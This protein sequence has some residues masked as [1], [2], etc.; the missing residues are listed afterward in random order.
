[1]HR[2]KKK[3]INW[4]EVFHDTE[5]ALGI[6]WGRGP[7]AWR[8]LQ[9]GEDL[10][11][12]HSLKWKRRQL[13]AN[14]DHGGRTVETKSDFPTRWRVNEWQGWFQTYFRMWLRQLKSDNLDFLW[15]ADNELV[16]H[17]STRSFVV[18]LQAWC[19]HRTIIPFRMKEREKPL[20]ILS[21]R[22]EWLRAVTVKLEGH[23]RVSKGR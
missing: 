11:S 1:M 12:H 21:P 9:V 18:R 16:S 4:F 17:C 19:L 3:I 22:G 7:R 10:C 23:Q 15:V 8:I 5:K 20:I 13:L 6:D 14:A 2:C